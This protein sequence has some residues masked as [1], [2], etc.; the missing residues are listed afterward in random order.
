[1]KTKLTP[2][3]TEE[4]TKR[5]KVG[6]YAKMAAA[7]IGVPE[8]S[9]YNWLERGLKAEKLAEIG[10]KIPETEKIFWQFWQSVRQSEAEA[11]VMLTSMVFSQAPNDWRAAIELMARKWPEQ[12]ARKEYLDFKGSVDQGY[13]KG[14]EALKEFDETFKD[15]PKGELSRI[16]SETTQKL[17]D[18]KDKFLK[19]K[20]LKN[21]QLKA[22]D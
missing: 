13:D 1:M 19:E 7:A 4:I 22:P 16:L 3:I 2:Q 14:K 5:L 18:A 9:Y 8:R 21:K 17:R 15:V 20:E 12:W 6:C 10:K 11:Q